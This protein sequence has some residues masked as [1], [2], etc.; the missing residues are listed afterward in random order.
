MANPETDAEFSFAIVNAP[1]K[2][3]HVSSVDLG[4]SF[5]LPQLRALQLDGFEVHAACAD[6]PSSMS[7]MTRTSNP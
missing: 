7:A 4:I 5:L 2:V 1:L 3:L 6:G